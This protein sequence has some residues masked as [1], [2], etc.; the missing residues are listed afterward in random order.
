MVKDN[1]AVE[2]YLKANLSKHRWSIISQL[3]L[4]ILPLKIESGR[5]QKLSVAERVCKLCNDEVETE[6]HFVLHC[7]KLKS[8]RDCEMESVPELNYF[9]EDI[10]KLQYLSNMPYFFSNLLDKLWIKRETLLNMQ[11]QSVMSF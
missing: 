8:V 10:A 1:M 11:L 4:G 9:D 3:R 2:N 6:C 5:Y 7:W